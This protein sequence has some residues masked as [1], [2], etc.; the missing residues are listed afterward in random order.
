MSTFFKFLG[1]G[2][3][4]MWAIVLTGLFALGVVIERFKTL[5]VDFNINSHTFMEKIRALILG[6]K[7]EEAVAH[8]ANHPKVPLAQV[9]K[10]VLER[11][12]QDDSS[13]DNGLDVKF[14]EVMPRLHKGFGYLSMVA[15]VATL[16]G[17]LGTVHGLVMAFEAVSFA[18]P[19]QKQIMLAQSISIAMVATMAGLFVAIPVMFIYSFFHAKQNQLVEEVI[20]C[21]TVVVDLLKHRNYE[22]FKE[23]KVYAMDKKNLPPVP[24]RK[25]A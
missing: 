1:D 6:D 23:E 21:S 24:Q 9:V 2:D 10:G 19:A 8:C 4:A 7:I 17:L 16:L 11:A 5:Y 20:A 22:P 18:D 12:D 13:I 3:V 25:M 14:T 15:N